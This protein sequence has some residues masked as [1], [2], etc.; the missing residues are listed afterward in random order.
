MKRGT[1][2]VVFG[3]TLPHGW[4]SRH[5]Y[6]AVIASEKLRQSIEAADVPFV[7]IEPF[8]GTGNIYEA[9]ALLE[10]LSRL[11]YDDG[12]RLSKSCVYKGYELWWTHY[13]S[14]FLYFCLPFTQYKKL[15]ERLKSFRNVYMYR[16]PHI[17][18]FAYYL[19]VYNTKIQV[20]SGSDFTS[21]S[22]LPFGVFLQMLITLLYVP[23]LMLKRRHIMVYTGD[24]FEKNKDYD[25]RMKFI[26]KELR[27]RR[28][29]FVEC[30]RSLESWR[31]VLQHAF[32]RRRPVIYSEIATFLGRFCSILS[33][34]RQR[35]KREFGA[36]AFV[37]VTDLELRF[38]LLVASHY[39]ISTY[40]DIWATR[41]MKWILRATGVKAAFIPAGTERNFHTVLG[42][43]LNT[44]PTVGILHG[45]ATKS[46]IVYDFMPGFDGEKTISVD[47]YGLWSEWWRAYYIKNSR[48]YRPGQLY[49]SG[50]MRPLEYADLPVAPH[51]KG[52][53]LKVL[54]IG[55]QLGVPAEVL[56]YLS[57][58]LDAKDLSLYVKFRPYR[59]GLEE[60]L[61]EYRP[62]VLKR[63]GKAK[64]M[65][66]DMNEAIAAC[67]VV[68]GSHST[69][70]LEALLQLKPPLFYNTNKWGDYF[71]L[72]SFDSKYSF[73][74]ET[75]KELLE[76]VRKS[77]DIPQATLKE[78][79]ER[80][81]GDPYMNGSKWVVDQLEDT[82]LNGCATK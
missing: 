62:D 5:A 64:I 74:A 71:E 61:K 82:L 36:H 35:A 30:I 67:D 15:L 26:Y 14:L 59:D 3:E 70:V 29:P 34:G 50:P 27:E 12:T 8:I 20:L 77:N 65:R 17:N 37:S 23:M 68:V 33:G 6:T 40:E 53:P 44:I 57:L 19:H 10:E 18:L 45:A 16:P 28:I 38:K 73:I 78:L 9:N 48:A 75:P 79:Q 13:D 11:N 52:G 2:L 55:E 47:T 60:W 72:K 4:E 31:T 56:P 63:I 22:F 1:V 80:F 58:L 66:G 76:L 21:P 81:F 69:A 39:L 49:I 54:F 24:K 7:P 32:T 25:S 41:I 46:Y 51:M 42:C 43:K